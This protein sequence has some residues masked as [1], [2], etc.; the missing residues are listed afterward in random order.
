MTLRYTFEKVHG[1]EW[2]QVR[3][4]GE[5]ITYAERKDSKLVDEILRDN[6]FESREVYWAYLMEARK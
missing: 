1:E 6:G 3:L 5:F 4:N 2:Y